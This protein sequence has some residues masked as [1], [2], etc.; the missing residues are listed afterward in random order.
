RVHPRPPHGPRRAR[1]RGPPP[2][3]AGPAGRLSPPRR[4]GLL[5][6]RRRVG[7]RSGRRGRPAS[8]RTS[9]GRR[10]RRPR[11]GGPG[12]PALGPAARPDVDL[13]Q[14]ERAAHALDALEEAIEPVAAATGSPRAARADLAAR[15]PQALAAACAVDDSPALFE[16]A[17]R[18]DAADLSPFHAAVLI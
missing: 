15:D 10:R 14:P 11:A 16:D 8:A 13:A 18:W 2:G 12:R 9:D 17:L 1:A 6:R 4:G 5:R 3:P 7:C